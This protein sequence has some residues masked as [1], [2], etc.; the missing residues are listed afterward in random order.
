VQVT[1]HWD[2][3]KLADLEVHHLGRTVLFTDHGDW[4]DAAIIAAYRSQGTVENAFRQMKNPHFFTVQ[5]IFHWTDPKIRVHI[6]ICVIALML[7]SLLYR[8][9]R[10]GGFPHGFDALME[11]LQQM[12]AVV[13]LLREGS[14]E[15]PQIR[16]TR[17]TADQEALYQRLGLASF[18]PTTA[19]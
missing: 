5:P 12:R 13:D 16:L 15:R 14:R 10:Q 18:D 6:A 9:A 4:D 3:D 1:Y 11:T 19:H 8:E 7:V 2:A 17:R